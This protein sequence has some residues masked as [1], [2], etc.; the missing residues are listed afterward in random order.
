MKKACLLSALLFASVLTASAQEPRIRVEA[1]WVRPSPMVERAGA[2]YMVLR[3]DGEAPDA[4][5]GATTEVAGMVELHETVKAGDM[6]HMRPVSRIEV[7]ARG[8]VELK[9]GG[10]H[11]MLMHMREGLPIGRKVRLILKFEKLG[12]V[13]IDAEARKQ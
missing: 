6:M 8:A 9:P 1:A 10:L 5:I 7:P 3:N 12:E 2:A 13:P 11:L 4:L